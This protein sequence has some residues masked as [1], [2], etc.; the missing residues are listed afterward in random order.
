MRV[1]CDAMDMTTDKAKVRYA[2]LS[3]GEMTAADLRTIAE[4]TP[5]I[6]LMER[7]GQAVADAIRSRWSKRATLV[8]CGPGN[9]G[10]DG[11][12]VACLLA[13]AGWPVR[14]ALLG[15]MD[16][17]QGDA[18]QMAERWSG[19]V[20]CWDD[21]DAASAGLI[22]DAVF[23]A[24]LSRRLSEKVSSVL[25]RIASPCVAV[26]LP[27]GVSGDSGALLGPAPRA[28]LTVT[29][30]RAKP[31][32]LLAPGRFHCGDVV[33]ADIGITDETV[34]ILQ[35]SLWQN[36][37]DL[38]R[39]RWPWPDGDLH[40]Y[41][42][43]HLF[44]VGGGMATS[45]AARLAARAGLRA[46]AGLVT[47]AVPRSALLVYASQQTSVMTTPLPTPDALPELMEERRVRA[48]ALGPGQGLSDATQGNVLKT[49][50]LGTPCVLDADALTVFRDNAD[51]L[52]SALHEHC[53]LTPHEGE[54][55]RL[56]HRSDNKLKD[57]R[58]AAEVAG[59]V[60]LLKGPDTVIAEPAGDTVINDNGPADLATAGSGDVLAGFVGGLLA[61]GCG[62]FDAAAMG[63]WLHGEA[64]RQVGPG[65]IAEDLPEAV[66]AVL[67]RL[68]LGAV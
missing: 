18:A 43:G 63:A 28:D 49:L 48:V 51:D 5:V 40:K 52:F 9:N 61:Q 32:H 66:P 25:E 57:V 37:P 6:T 31:G 45:G 38:W 67:R 35:P 10:G 24:G 64:G 23:G 42:R 12:A 50:S 16:A 27:S 53:V 44:V 65:L 4:G 54:F 39:R 46:G 33:V 30:C 34:N 14:V 22:V 36:H 3:V 26:D 68:K 47:C 7:A 58:H 17:M 29:F 15:P 41:S 56:F 1:L 59:C 60:V 62:P 11:F 55:Q 21:V 20:E 13:E 19:S 2:L 8:L